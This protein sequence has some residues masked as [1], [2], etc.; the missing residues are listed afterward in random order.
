MYRPVYA[1]D[2]KEEGG[3]DVA[4][5]PDHHEQLAHD[6]P[7]VPL[8]GQPPEGLHRQRDVGGDGVR[9]GQMEHQVVNIGAA[10]QLLNICHMTPGPNRSLSLLPHFTKCEIYSQLPKDMCILCTKLGYCTPVNIE[11][12]TKFNFLFK[13]YAKK[14]H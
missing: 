14:N 13:K 9:Q 8:V 3:E 11:K 4:A 6:V 1:E 10:P 5:G 7:G 2:D 12:S